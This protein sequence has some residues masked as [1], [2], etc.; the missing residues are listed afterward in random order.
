MPVFSTP[1]RDMPDVPQPNLLGFKRGDRVVHEANGP[2]TVVNTDTDRVEVAFDHPGRSV[3]ERCVY[4]A[5]W[6]R[7]FADKLR[8]VADHG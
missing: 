5:D 8:R 7:L 3:P 6:F 2:G 1:P 4:G